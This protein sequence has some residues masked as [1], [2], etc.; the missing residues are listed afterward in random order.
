MSTY[1]FAELEAPSTMTSC[2]E[3]HAAPSRVTSKVAPSE[4]TERPRSAAEATEASRRRRGS[5]TIGFAV[6]PVEMGSSPARL[7]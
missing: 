4:E 7:V 2:P 5:T 3:S 1:V 6:R